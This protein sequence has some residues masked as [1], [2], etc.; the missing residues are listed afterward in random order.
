MLKQALLAL[1]LL[2]G[3]CDP[4]GRKEEEAR[5]RRSAAGQ[6]AEREA[7]EVKALRA[8]LAVQ[9]ANVDSLAAEMAKERDE[10]KRKIIQ[11]QLEAAEEEANDTRAK[12]KL[13]PVGATSR[14][15][16]AQPVCSCKAT[17]P[18]CDCL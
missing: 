15:T 13:P 8:E 9:S 11:A 14:A 17:D 7:E 16:A 12:L 2:V 10:H 1:T 5:T 6:L 4:W 18:L 3:P